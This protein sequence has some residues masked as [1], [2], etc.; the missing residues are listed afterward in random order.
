MTDE[1]YLYPY[2]VTDARA[3]DELPL[4]RASF[5]ANCACKEA[6]ENAI[7]HNYD[8]AYLNT[9]CAKSVIAEYG[10]KRVEF[11]LANTLKELSYDGRFSPSNKAWGSQ[12]YIPPDR[13]HNCQFIVASHPAVLDGFINQYRHAVTELG[14]FDYTYCE[15][16]SGDMNFEG[17]VLVLSPQV[18][19]DACWRPEDQLWY[20][21]DGFGCRPKAIGRSVRCTCLGDGEETRW[22]RYDFVGVLKEEY[23]PD[24]AQESLA[25]LQNP[26]QAPEMGGMNMN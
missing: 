4:W 26:E 24:W 12:T 22:N 19:R 18:L 11:V 8:G 5:H 15:P 2:S 1:I 3:R 20:A 13:D 14:M 17:K 7:R 21:H 25:K 9:D 16:D 23:L 10:Y 6:I